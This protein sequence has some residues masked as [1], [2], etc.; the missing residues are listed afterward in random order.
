MFPIL[1]FKDICGENVINSDTE[2]ATTYCV[3]FYY[4]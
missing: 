2:L 1:S 4:L 3:Q